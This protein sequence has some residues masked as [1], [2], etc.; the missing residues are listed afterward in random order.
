MS[1]STTQV[2]QIILDALVMLVVPFIVFCVINI[3]TLKTDMKWVIG[4]MKLLGDKAGILLHSPHSPEFDLLTEKFWSNELTSD[5]AKRLCGKL[6][7]IIH[8]DANKPIYPG[9]PYTA[10]QKATATQMIAA[11]STICRIGC[12]NE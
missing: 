9:K 11:V 6:E 5:D 12:K 8:E 3:V 2:I 10:G 4:G 1:E 7:A